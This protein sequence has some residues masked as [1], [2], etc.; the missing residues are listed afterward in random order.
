VNKSIHRF[1]VSRETF[2]WL[3]CI[4]KSRVFTPVVSFPS[5]CIWQLSEGYEIVCLVK[6]TDFP[7]NGLTNVR[8]SSQ[9]RLLLGD[10]AC[11]RERE[12]LCVCARMFMWCLWLFW[13]LWFL[14][15]TRTFFGQTYTDEEI[16][17]A[18][19]SRVGQCRLLHQWSNI[20]CSFSGE[21]DGGGLRV[22]APSKKCFRQ[23]NEYIII[24]TNVCMYV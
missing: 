23:N 15:Q 10:R 5:L 1:V 14:F 9:A 20:M 18:E 12:C 22:K 7:R 6:V 16:R 21:A 19:S 17:H 11:V 8:V 13:S 24:Y 2:F 4:F 3:G